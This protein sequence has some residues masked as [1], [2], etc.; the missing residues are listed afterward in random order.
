MMNNK[1]NL[2]EIVEK[3]EDRGLFPEQLARVKEQL[4][5]IHDMKWKDRE[6]RIERVVEGINKLLSDNGCYLEISEWLSVIVENENG[7]NYGREVVCKDKKLKIS[8]DF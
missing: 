5:N 4:K 2:K 3:L 6:E 7:K 1:I 8:K